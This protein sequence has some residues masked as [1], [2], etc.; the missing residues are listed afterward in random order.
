MSDGDSIASGIVDSAK[1]FGKGMVSEV[2]NS[3][4]AAVKSAGAQVTG[5]KTAEEEAKEKMAKQATF[6][7]IKEIEAEMAQIRYSS[8]QKNNSHGPAITPRTVT[9]TESEDSNPQRTS[10]I[11][12][13]SRQA[14]GKAEQGR[15]FKG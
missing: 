5:A 1:D 8:E 9:I 3:A 11:D 4:G 14:V 2:I 13:S 6:N 10:K 15:N 12:E 7:R